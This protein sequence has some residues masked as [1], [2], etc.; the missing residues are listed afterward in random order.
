MSFIKDLLTTTIDSIP[1]A[2]SSYQI[3]G[4]PVVALVA[5]VNRFVGRKVQIG[6]GDYSCERSK[7]TLLPDILDG[8]LTKFPLV[9]NA[10]DSLNALGLFPGT[11]FRVTELLV[12]AAAHIVKQ[13]YA[14]VDI[15]LYDPRKARWTLMIHSDSQQNLAWI[16][17]NLK[18]VTMTLAQVA[19]SDGL[20]PAEQG[21]TKPDKN[22]LPPKTKYGP[23]IAAGAGLLALLGVG[24]FV[25]SRRTQRVLPPAV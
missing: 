12:T 1:G 20:P 15:D 21:I 25:F 3:E 18:E 14:C 11:N 24:A 10:L 4:D 22:L 19:D 17:Q 9:P 23:Y 6:T 5:Q 8:K 16:K 13:R 7:Q 2:G